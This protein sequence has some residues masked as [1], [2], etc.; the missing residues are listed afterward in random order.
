MFPPLSRSR[1][2]LQGACSPRSLKL[3]HRVASLM[4]LTLGWP[5]RSGRDTI[6]NPATFWSRT[7]VS[8]P[9]QRDAT[10]AED[11]NGKRSPTQKAALADNKA[12]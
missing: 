8:T 7:F 6:N 4:V 1:G 3:K 2:A 5:F 11:A 10:E 9:I 12:A